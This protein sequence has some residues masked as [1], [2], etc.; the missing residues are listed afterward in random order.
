MPSPENGES[1]RHTK[2]DK[3]LQ[4]EHEA[5][6]VRGRRVASCQCDATALCENKQQLLV[7]EEELGL[8]HLIKVSAILASFDQVVY[9]ENLFIIMLL[10]VNSLRSGQSI[11][12]QLVRLVYF[13]K[14]WL[15]LVT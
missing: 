4:T 1:Y 9:Q 7:C 10:I 5:F 6:P 3:P 8:E 12:R 11:W 13:N 15:I 2:T 14:V